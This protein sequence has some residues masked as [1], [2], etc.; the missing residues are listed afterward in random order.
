M[1]K[2][3]KLLLVTDSVFCNNPKK[4]NGKMLLVFCQANQRDLNLNLVGL[5]NNVIP[6]ALSSCGFLQRS[7]VSRQLAMVNSPSVVVRAEFAIFVRTNFIF[8][9]NGSDA[10]SELNILVSP[11]G[12]TG[13]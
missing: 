11:Q 9:L 7:A 8:F 5:Q 13:G 12:L 2:Y 10:I 6:T 3:H 4:N 1:C